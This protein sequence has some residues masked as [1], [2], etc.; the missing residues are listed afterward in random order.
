M[1]KIKIV[2]ALIFT[3]S[4]T[5]AII[6]GYTSK[7]ISE[8]NDFINAINKQKDFTQEISKNIFYIYKNPTSSA[9]TLDDSIKKFLD[10]M[11][12]RNENSK[13]NEN[14]AKLWNSF[15]LNVQTFRDQFKNRSIYSNILFEKSVK[16]I[17]NTNLRL[18]L[19]FNNIVQKEKE[20]F[21]EKQQ[22]YKYLQYLLFTLLVLLLLFLFTELK[23]VIAF[24]QKFLSASKEIISNSSIKELKPIEIENAGTDI[25]QAK[26]N[27][28]SLVKKINDSIEYSGNSIE[29]AHESLKVTER[30]IEDLVELIYDMNDKTRDKELRKKE[31][32]VIQSLEELSS[33]AVKLKNLKKDLDSLILYS[34][35]KN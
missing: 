8:H 13:T 9:K 16:E 34:K 27:F 17:Y 5:L 22:F 35:L 14:I 26:D 25:I 31:D 7:N 12:T 32:A 6:F 18:I 2:G 3:L 4:I 30:H 10:V 11:N 23:T 28:N 15:Y 1:K 20:S 29:Y 24:V 21:E 33:T 19:E